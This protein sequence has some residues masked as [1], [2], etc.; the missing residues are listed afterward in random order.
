MPNGNFVRVTIVLP[1]ELDNVLDFIRKK[2]VM[3]SKSALIRDLLQAGIDK[4]YPGA[5]EEYRDTIKDSIVK[6]LIE[7]RE[8]SDGVLKEHKNEAKSKE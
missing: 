8:Q 1:N 5:K 2:K 4:L 7:G 3:L 6:G